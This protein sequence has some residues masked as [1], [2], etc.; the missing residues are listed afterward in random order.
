MDYFFSVKSDIRVLV[1]IKLKIFN[2]INLIKKRKLF[3]TLMSYLD[4]FIEIPN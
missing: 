2:K 3:E 4:F 1:L